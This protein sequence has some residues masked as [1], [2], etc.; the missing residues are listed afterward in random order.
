MA[1]IAVE[2]FQHYISTY[3]L[4]LFFII[5][6]NQYAFLALGMD[7]FVLFACSEC[8]GICEV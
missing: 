8:I 2:F 4:T 5:Y 7:I 3:I 1:C 6:R